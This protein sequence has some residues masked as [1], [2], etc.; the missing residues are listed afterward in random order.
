M[1]TTSTNSVLLTNR[2]PG[3]TEVCLSRPTHANALDEEM[4]DRIAEAVDSI[5]A[6]PT[7]R[8]VILRG[9]GRHFCAGGDFAFIESNT[10]LDQSVVEE[11]MLRFYQ[12]YL[13]LLDLRVPTIAALQGSAIGAGLCLALACDLRVGHPDSRLSLNFVR[14]GLHPGMGATCL[15][16]ARCGH[17]AAAD[18]MLSGRT[19]GAEEA[20]RLGLLT[21][22]TAADA[23]PGEQA[24]RLSAQQIAEGIAAAAPIAV[25]QTV[26]TLRGPLRAS[27]G[28]ALRTEAARQAHDFGTR[29]VRRAIQA[30]R[31]RS[32][33]NFEGD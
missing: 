10:A 12:R 15:V 24:T 19:V 4:G 32:A 33:P 22:V 6:D 2:G 1:T 8:A 30:F 21:H 29:D 23:T 16:P 17:S 14:I 26:S 18:L 28:P 9:V 3:V 7:V 20:L 11:R 25:R 5:N 31:A 27:L 13:E